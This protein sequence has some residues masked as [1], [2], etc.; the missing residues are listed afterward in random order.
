MKAFLRYKLGAVTH[1]NLITNNIVDINGNHIKRYF[2]N[3]KENLNE[4]LKFEKLQVKEIKELSVKELKVKELKVVELKELKVEEIIV[5]E[6]GNE[7]CF[8]ESSE[9][10]R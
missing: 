3:S 8:V 6:N 5:T 9:L 7:Y 1:I 2:N 4:K 10:Y